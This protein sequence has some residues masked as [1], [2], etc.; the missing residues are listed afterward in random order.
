MPNLEIKILHTWAIISSAVHYFPWLFIII[1]T[2]YSTYPNEHRVAVVG[3]TINIFPQS[4]VHGRVNDA[5]PMAE[6]H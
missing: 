2:I 4:R 1:I 3:E 5:S 6:E